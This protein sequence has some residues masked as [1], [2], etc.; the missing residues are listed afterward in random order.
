MLFGISPLG[1]LHTLGSLP[2]IPLALYMLIR[3]GRIVPRSVTGYAYL[4]FMMLGA[5]TVFLIA[6]EPVSYVIGGVTLTV[7]ALGYGAAYL[8]LGRAT[9]YVETISLTFSAFLLALPTTSEVLRRVPDGHPIASGLDSPILLAAQGVLALLL[10]I[11]LTAQ[12]IGLR[13]TT[14]KL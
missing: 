7:L 9:R 11:G 3:H 1:W 12:V 10:V 14:P 13:H 8:P 2:A 4:G 6:K 5:V